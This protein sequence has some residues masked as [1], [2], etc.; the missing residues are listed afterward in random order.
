MTTT[1]FKQSLKERFIYCYSPKEVKWLKNYGI[2]YICKAIH[3]ST[4]CPY[5]LYDRTELTE[6]YLSY[7]HRRNEPR[8][9]F[10]GVLEEE[11]F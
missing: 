5:W 2:R 8:L 11:L 6:L 9:P 7:F 3:P 1:E 4:K 10:N